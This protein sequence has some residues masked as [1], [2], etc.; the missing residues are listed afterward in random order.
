MGTDSVLAARMARM[1]MPASWQRPA[2]MSDESFPSTNPPSPPPTTM[3]H[4]TE[5]IS[6]NP[7]TVP[8]PRTRFNPTLRDLDFMTPEQLNLEMMS[9]GL[10]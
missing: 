4:L 2:P 7:S 6:S 5:A 3:A 1:Q 9:R 8:P 10:P